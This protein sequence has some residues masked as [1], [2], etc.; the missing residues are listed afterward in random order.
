MD[1]KE[2]NYSINDK[3]FPRGEVH[4]GGNT[5]GKGYYKMPEKTAED[6]YDENGV[7]WFKTGDIG[8]LDNTGNLTLIG[9]RVRGI[10]YKTQLVQIGRRIWSNCAMEST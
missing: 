6:F 8:L 4:V 5:V 7:R 9:R 1:W 2:G 3:P 10:R